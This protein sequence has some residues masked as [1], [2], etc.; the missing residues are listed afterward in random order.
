MKKIQHSLILLIVLFSFT[1]VSATVFTP[2]T[3]ELFIGINGR[4]CTLEKAI[5]IQKIKTK[6]VNV[7]SVHTLK[8]KDNVWERFYLENYKKMNDTTYQIKANSEEFTG[9]MYR[10]FKLLAD[11]SF[12]F[13]DTVKGTVIREGN[14]QS[15]MPL[16]LN[17]EVTEYYR[18]GNK[19][20]VSI[21]QNNELVSNENWNEDGTKYIDNLFYSTDIEP[22][23]VPG[24]KVMNQHL[25][26][27][28]KDAGIDISSISGTLVVAFVIMEDGK[29]EG[30]K[31]VKGLGSSVNTAAYES[32]LS[33]QGDWKPAKLNNKNVRYYLSF[34]I[35]FINKQQAL[36]FAELRKGILH[37][38]AY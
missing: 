11:K 10:T 23:F 3:S 12:R 29:M 32:F 13:R 31:I 17:G 34:P 22:N 9:T 14:A 25:I 1:F 30:L 2:K 15:V 19:K 26:K 35:N 27:G 8:L 20:S 21:Y 4:L 6:S 7:A 33:L 18:D 38:G 5:Y 16:L 37:F 24:T 28:F 36:E